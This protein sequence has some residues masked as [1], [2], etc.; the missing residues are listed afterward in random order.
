[1]NESNAQ[2]IIAPIATSIPITAEILNKFHK[3]GDFSSLYPTV[4]KELNMLPPDELQ[5][6]LNE[7]QVREDQF[8][9]YSIMIIERK[10][11]DFILPNGFK[12][13]NRKPLN[14]NTIKSWSI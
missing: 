11:E 12:W 14:K 10:A 4:I 13:S 7:M 6:F 5:K 8:I 9:D 3:S 2:G 1:M